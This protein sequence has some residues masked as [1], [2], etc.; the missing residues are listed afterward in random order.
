MRSVVYLDASLPRRNVIYRA[1]VSE[2]QVPDG[3]E[4]VLRP[5]Q[6]GR[7]TLNYYLRRCLANAL[8]VF[9]FFQFSLLLAL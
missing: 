8:I 7:S 4:T 2:N 1:S 9:P 5:C 3:A 6:R